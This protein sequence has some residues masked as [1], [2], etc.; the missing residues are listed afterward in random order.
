[1]K[2]RF[3]LSPL[4]LRSMHLLRS[5][6]GSCTTSLVRHRSLRKQTLHAMSTTATAPLLI[7]PSELAQS[8][9]RQNRPPVVLDGSWHM[10]NLKPPR[11]A[12]AEYR[13]K[14]IPGAR[15]WHV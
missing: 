12:Y 11:D 1:M 9:K 8:L 5:G 13:H 10:P 3:C 4:L 6:S 7:T 2:W 15:F 14:R